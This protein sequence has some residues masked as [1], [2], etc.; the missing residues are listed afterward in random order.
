MLPRLPRVKRKCVSGLLIRDNLERVR[1]VQNVPKPPIVVLITN[2]S[3]NLQAIFFLQ[4]ARESIVKKYLG[5]SCWLFRDYF[6]LLLITEN[7]IVKTVISEIIK[8][9]TH[10]T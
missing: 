6:A 7:I 8:M 2:S 3:V 5:T 10:I 4:N 1:S 9:I